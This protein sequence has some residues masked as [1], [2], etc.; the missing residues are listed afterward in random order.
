MDS[1]APS[2][3]LAALGP[4]KY[5]GATPK[6]WHGQCCFFVGGYACSDK[7]CT[8]DHIVNKSERPPCRQ[9]VEHNSC[10]RGEQCWLPHPEPAREYAC[11]I[12]LQVNKAHAERAVQYIL[13][14]Y[15]VTT[16]KSAH[17]TTAE[18]KRQRPDL[19]MMVQADEAEVPRILSE[20]KRD[21][22]IAIALRRAYAVTYCSTF[23]ED[24]MSYLAA[25]VEKRSASSGEGRPPAVSVRA[26]CYPPSHEA[27]LIDWLV[28][29]NGKI[30]DA[31]EG[32]PSELKIEPK[33]QAYDFLLM[34]VLAEGYY[35]CGVA[36]PADP[37]FSYGHMPTKHLKDDAVCRAYYKLQ[38]LSLRTGVFDA[39]QRL[40]SSETTQRR[41]AMDVGAAPGGWST[42]LASHAGFGTV[43]AVDP[44]AMD[45]SLPASIVHMPVRADAAVA[46]LLSRGLQGTVA[47]YACDMN[48]PTSTTVDIFL[49]ALPLLARDAIVVLTLK[50]F[51]GALFTWKQNCELAA[52][53]VAAACGVERGDVKIIH[54]IANGPAE[55]TLLARYRA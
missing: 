48:C 18:R 37:A 29:R 33:P 4:S 22:A 52:Q 12:V 44:G 26:Q 25:E 15:G 10:K 41:V 6:P 49:S 47:C 46:E 34:T 43:Y 2:A 51:D 7:T 27:K 30:L 45:P 35:Y 21:E 39:Q 5:S 53:R 50:N 24:C 1:H 9:H 42:Y 8:G 40:D 16:I 11:N 32:G 55:V 31:A 38:E 13:D 17:L 19:V 23:Y 14:R 20:L 54:L 28:A 36:G 3:A